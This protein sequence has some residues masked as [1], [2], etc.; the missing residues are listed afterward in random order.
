VKIF[1]LTIPLDENAPV[2]P[3]V[4]KP[5][6]S[7]VLNIDTDGFNELML[8]FPTHTGTHI[9]APFHC[10]KNGKKLSDYDI[11]YFV[12]EAIVFDC[13]C[14]KEIELS[15]TELKKIKKDDFVFF[16]TGHSDNYKSP[17]YFTNYPVISKETAQ[18]LVAKKVKVIGIDSPSPDKAPY[19]IHYILLGKGIPI[20]ENLYNLATRVGKRFKC[21]IAP[22]HIQNADGAPCRVIGID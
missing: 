9:D 16:Y 12:G 1:D 13:K 4:P 2:Y 10:I 22:L 7:S 6:I 19:K 8:S 18:A 21:I 3:G 5:K 11:S 14:Q 17:N 15:E 20:V